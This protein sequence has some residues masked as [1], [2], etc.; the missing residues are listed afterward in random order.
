M[1]VWQPLIDRSPSK[2]GQAKWYIPKVGET[3]RWINPLNAKLNPICHLLA[4]LEAR[5]ILHVSGLRVKLPWMTRRFGNYY[6]WKLDHYS[7]WLGDQK[8]RGLRSPRMN[9]SFYLPLRQRPNRYAVHWVPGTLLT[10]VKTTDVWRWRLT[11]YISN[12]KH[13]NSFTGRF[14]L[15][16]C[17]TA[18][19]D[20]WH[21]SST[22]KY[23]TGWRNSLFTIE[24]TR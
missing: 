21:A 13:C 16:L 3:R 20:G 23:N 19:N 15:L 12:F 22:V 6:S 11:S 24:T 8:H 2:P 17:R 7:Y 1:A 10:D 18:N 9:R 4:L 5:H 14:L